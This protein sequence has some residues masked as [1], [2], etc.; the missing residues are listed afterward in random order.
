ME[1]VLTLLV[2]LLFFAAMAVGVIF[3]K[4]PLSGSCGGVAALM[5]DKECQ[6]CG[7]DPN[8]C[9]N[10]TAAGRTELAA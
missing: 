4:K 3:R 1:I 2:F 5:G 10:G 7:G 6:F 8:R 9:D